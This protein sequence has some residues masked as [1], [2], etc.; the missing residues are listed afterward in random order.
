MKF[1]F[2]LKKKNKMTGGSPSPQPPATLFVSISNT[3]SIQ[4]LTLRA[5]G[6][7]PPLPP[8]V[9]HSVQVAAQY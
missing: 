5:A 6:S 9:L 8:P 4:I 3:A 2:K 7:L 1:K